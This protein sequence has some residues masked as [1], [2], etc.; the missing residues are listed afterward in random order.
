MMKR[1]LKATAVGSVSALAL[2]AMASTAQADGPELYGLVDVGLEG[3]SADDGALGN[4]FPGMNS[5]AGNSDDKDFTLTNGMSSRLGVR[6][7]EDITDNL[8]ASYNI[9][10]GVDILDEDGGGFSDSVGTRL[11][12]AA[13]EGDWGMAKI[14]TQWMALYEFGGWNTHRTDVHGYGSYYYT[15]GVL[16][17]SLGF[18]FRQSSAVSYQYGS[19]WGHSDP[20]AFNLTVGVGEGDD[21]DSGVSSIQAAGQYSFNN[22]I[23]VNAVVLQEIVDAANDANDDEA[24]LY[25]VGARWSVTSALE[26]AANY[27]LVTDYNDGMDADSERQ[28]FALA[29]YYDFGAGWNAHLGFGR[30]SADETADMDANVYGYVRHSFTDRTNARLEFEHI[31]YDSDADDASESL[32]MIALQHNF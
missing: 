23:S 25:N 1:T 32:G 8:R 26:L 6:G 5:T 24:T 2:A 10:L 31:E 28:A 9:E 16:R 12:W 17:D 27:T 15:T 11:G 14:G 3:Y 18:G 7:G 13:L 22:A 29:G 30:G 19:A 21:N 20:F 4:I